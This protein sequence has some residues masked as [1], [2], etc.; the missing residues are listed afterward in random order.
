M[1]KTFICGV[2]VSYKV[3]SWFTAIAQADYV[4]IANYGNVEGVK[5]ND[6]QLA[7]S[8]RFLF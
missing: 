7:V 5:Q 8:A 6:F 2:N 3:A 1:E 4:T